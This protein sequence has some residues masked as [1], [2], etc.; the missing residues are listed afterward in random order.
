MLLAIVP[1]CWTLTVIRFPWKI[2][3]FLCLRPRNTWSNVF[4]A[5]TDIQSLD[6]LEARAKAAG[7]SVR[8]WLLAAGVAQSTFYRAKRTSGDRMQVPTLKKL[9]DAIPAQP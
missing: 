8:Q 3:R 7:L 4:A 6:T 5:M 1:D 2:V 9:A